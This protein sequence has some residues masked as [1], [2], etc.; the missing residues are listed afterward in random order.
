MDTPSGPSPIADLGHSRL[1]LSRTFFTHRLYM[2]RDGPGQQ[3]LFNVL[4]SYARVNPVVGY[5]QVPK[6][7]KKGRRKKKKRKK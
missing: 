2:E 4:A 6:R 3:S 5:C 7:E 1:D